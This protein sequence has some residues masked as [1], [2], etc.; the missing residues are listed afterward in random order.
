MT[1]TTSPSPDIRRRY[2]LL[3][4]GGGMTA[5]AF[6]PTLQFLFDKWVNDPQYSHGFLVPAFAGYYLW[7]KAGVSPTGWFTVPRPLTAAAILALAAGFRGVAGGILFHQLDAF[8]LLLTLAALTL[9]VGGAAL[10]RRTGPA[11]LFLAFMVPLPYE[12][13]RNVGGPLRV[14]ATA[15][16]T[17][18]LQTLGQPAVSE[19]NV[20]L[21]DE[22]KLEVADACNG[23]KMLVTFAAF[24]VGA[25]LLSRRSWFE[26]A[27]VL[28]GIVPVAIVTNVLRI[29]ATGLAYTFD[30]G[31]ETMHTLHDV[32]GWLMMPVGLGLLAA[33]LWALNRLVVQRPL[34]HGD[35]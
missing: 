3:L 33:E 26:K 12:L 13:E 18:L 23:L 27:M 22:H 21:L 25:V 8:A 31:K 35:L 2:G 15:A 16:S 34:S 11:I 9:A 20:I 17:Y 10:F 5:W 14:V 32:F 1:E 30:P 28:L 7:Q 4:A 19:G 29:T 24:S 6:W